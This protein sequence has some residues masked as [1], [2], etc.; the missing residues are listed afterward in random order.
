MAQA[1]QTRDATEVQLVAKA[2]SDD[3][4]QQC[5]W[6]AANAGPTLWDWYEVAHN[7]FQELTNGTAPFDLVLP[8][9][10]IVRVTWQAGQWVLIEQQDTHR[11]YQTETAGEMANDLFHK[12]FVFDTRE[13][14]DAF[15]IKLVNDQKLRECGEEE[16]ED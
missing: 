7:L 6:L 10:D 12:V 4:Y 5:E 16:W 15:S 9:T 2:L 3:I 11:V 14:V 1:R 13:Q 8:S